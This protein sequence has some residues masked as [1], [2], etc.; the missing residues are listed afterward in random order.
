MLNPAKATITLADDALVG[1]EPRLMTVQE[2]ASL[3][4][5]VRL[6]RVRP[7][8]R[9]MCPRLGDFWKAEVAAANVPTSTNRRARAAASLARVYRNNVEGCC[10]V[11][12]KMHLLGLWSG[13]DADHD[14][15]A[16]VLASDDEVHA[17][18][19]GVCGPGDQG[20]VI[21]QV[22]DYMRVQGML[23]GGIRYK[24]DGYVSC[25][26]RNIELVKTAIYAFGGLTIGINLPDAWTRAAV[27][28]VTTTRIVG[29]HDVSVIDFSPDG[30]YVSSWGRIYLITW[31]AF[32]STRWLEECYVPLAPLWY[33]NDRLAPSGIDVAG[34]QGMLSMIS[35]G[36]VP[37]LPD[38]VPPPVPVPPP[39]P[40]PVDDQPTELR[41]INAAGKTVLGYELGKKVA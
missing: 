8:A 37:P 4:T 21:T 24:I 41:L 34:L 10:V 1:V 15:P 11:S 14:G 28:D 25:D 39:G 12:G 13:N 27:W 7:A 5:T 31:R 9:A 32:T 18:Y 23:A 17:Q 26:W 3:P 6:G 16:L 40:V 30:V 19:V 33:G 29:G 2:A 36:Q 22:L 35:H 20:C 38:P